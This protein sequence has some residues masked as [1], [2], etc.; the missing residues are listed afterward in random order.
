VPGARKDLLEAG[1]AGGELGRPGGAQATEAKRVGRRQVEGKGHW[2]PFPA[3]D[4]ARR[5]QH[6]LDAGE[7]LLHPDSWTSR[8]QL[9]KSTNTAARAGPSPKVSLSV[10]YCS[11]VG[12][13]SEPRAIGRLLRLHFM[14]QLA[15]FCLEHQMQCKYATLHIN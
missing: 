10:T 2:R 5:T 15:G 8:P 7:R 6:A 13:A 11:S 9:D 3:D 14:R 12:H 4:G 1:G